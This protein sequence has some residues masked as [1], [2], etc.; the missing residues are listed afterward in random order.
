MPN[1]FVKRGD[2]F[3]VG[4]IP[5]DRFGNL[6]LIVGY[7]KIYWVDDV[8]GFKKEAVT[9]SNVPRRPAIY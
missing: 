8:K 7:I 4:F 1:I 5:F 6:G 2:S 9:L 3:F